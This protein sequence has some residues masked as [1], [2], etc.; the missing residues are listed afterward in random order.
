KIRD[1]NSGATGTL[2]FKGTITGTLSWNS[3]ALSFNFQNP[4][5]TLILGGR[6]YTVSLPQGPIHLPS[7][8][9]VP[10]R[11]EARVQV[12]TAPVATPSSARPVA[13]YSHSL[14]IRPGALLKGTNR[15]TS[16]GKSTGV[17]NIALQGAGSTTVRL[18][19][20]AVALPIARVT[21][22]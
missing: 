3:S 5:Q 20:P 21:S 10:N 1:D 9:S 15:S 13:R 14:S 2:T 4:T 19:G 18:G 16:N 12:S 7:P 17:V 11:L 6:M 8:N 22:T